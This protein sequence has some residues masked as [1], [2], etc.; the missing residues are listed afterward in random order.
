MR[1]LDPDGLA[2][3]ADFAA[4]IAA[5]PDEE[6]FLRWLHRDNFPHACPRLLF[7]GEAAAVETQL[8]ALVTGLPRRVFGDEPDGVV[9]WISFV[10][11]A[12][13]NT[14]R[15]VTLDDAAINVVNT[16]TIGLCDGKTSLELVTDPASDDLLDEA[17][18][19]LV[20][21]P[22]LAS[23]RLTPAIVE[24]ASADRRAAWSAGLRR[25]TRHRRRIRTRPHR[26]GFGTPCCTSASP[27]PS[28]T[29][30]RRSSKPIA[31]NRPGLRSRRCQLSLG[32][33][34]L[35]GM[36]AG[37]FVRQLPRLRLRPIGVQQGAEASAMLTL[38]TGDEAAAG[39]P[40]RDVTCHIP[41]QVASGTSV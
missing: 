38:E 12:A 13:A 4:T 32:V 14:A 18:R 25:P 11:I 39:S 17:E 30:A 27:R 35:G 9:A 6:W 22:M 29:S 23:F 40:T 15:L 8:A 34:V 24:R 21:G 31:V 5:R 16:P 3:W 20:D 41:F 1:L 26:A 10:G 7:A 19:A 36:F 37:V 28:G 33:L 2:A